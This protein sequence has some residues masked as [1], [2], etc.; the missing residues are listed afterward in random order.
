MNSLL[1]PVPSL[2]SRAVRLA[3]TTLATGATVV[4]AAFGLRIVTA[5]VADPT[6]LVPSGRRTGYPG[7]M[8]G[9]LNGLAQALP[10]HTFVLLL[11]GMTVA[12][13][14]V[15]VL[16]Q[17]LSPWFLAGA[18]VVMTALFAVAPPLLST[19]VF[20]YI[21]YGQMGIRG[22]NPY[23]HGPI[24]LVGQPVYGYTGHLW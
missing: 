8:H 23:A 10:L 24:A 21:A 11:A 1:L 12:W 17:A 19:D 14:L 5:A 2:Q 18:V 16:A 4:L 15:V 13:I 6:Y 22:I 7:W 9:P 3:A 20:N